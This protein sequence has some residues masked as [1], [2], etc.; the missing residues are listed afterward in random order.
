M[1]LDL[2]KYLTNK[3]VKI[4]NDDFNLDKLQ[5]DLRKG[6]VLESE[7]EKPDYSNY[8]KKEDYTKLQNDF[9]EL[10]TNYN[11][12]V[13]TLS[14]TNERI[15]KVTLE[16][17][18]VK[19]GFKEESFDEVAKLRHSLYADEKDDKTALTNIATKFK[20]TYFEDKGTQYT[21]AP[22]EAGMSNSNKASDKK[23]ITITRNTSLKD[24]MI[25][26]K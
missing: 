14:D 19:I 11:N 17:E 1:S 20:G 3:E 12:T 22:N 23:A 16:N 25:S 9:S 5:N 6:Y 24:M 15:A 4:N 21:S 7:V 2:S 8:I 13:K 26:K 18:M 10:E